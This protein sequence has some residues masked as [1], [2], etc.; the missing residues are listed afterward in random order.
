MPKNFHEQI[1]HQEIPLPSDRSTG[2]VFAGVAAIVAIL[3]RNDAWVL[4]IAATICV[5]LIAISLIVP[6]ILRPLNIVWFRFGMLLS[7][8]VNPVV[9]L[10][11]FAVTIVPFGLAFQL[12]SDPMRKKRSGSEESYWISKSH[13]EAKSSMTNQF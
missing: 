2:L 7:R 11:L 9:M 6:R 8:I 13:D 5:T 1:A 4:G 10:I 3:W 12:R